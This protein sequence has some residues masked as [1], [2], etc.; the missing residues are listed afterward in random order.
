MSFDV[1]GPGGKRIHYKNRTTAF[2]PL[3]R[4]MEYLEGPLAGSK[5]MTYYTPMG[6]K[7][8]ITVVGEFVSDTIPESEIKSFVLS[9]FEKGFDEDVENLKNFR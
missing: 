2:P 8:G 3:G 5:A 9:L 6:Q 7:T 1:E 4:I